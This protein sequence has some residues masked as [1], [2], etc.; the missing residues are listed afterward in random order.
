MDL[1]DLFYNILK[2]QKNYWI[3]FFKC[4]CP[5]LLEFP[6]KINSKSFFDRKTIILIPIP[7][8]N[9]SDDSNFSSSDDEETFA[10]STHVA[11]ASFDSDWSE[12]DEDVSEESSRDDSMMIFMSTLI[13]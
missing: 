5:F 12:L 8:D 9:Q 13:H 1:Q 3:N 4:V 2:V 7:Q 10:P 6:K 11:N